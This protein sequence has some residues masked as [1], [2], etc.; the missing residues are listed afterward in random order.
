M[1]SLSLS[2]VHIWKYGPVF[3]YV[4]ESSN[5]NV[6]WE[7]YNLLHFSDCISAGLVIY[8]P[9]ILEDHHLAYLVYQSASIWG[10]KLLDYSPEKY[11]SIKL[12]ETY[13]KRPYTVRTKYVSTWKLFLLSFWRKL[14]WMS[15][16]LVKGVTLISLIPYR[17]LERRRQ[18][19]SLVLT[20]R[21][22]W[23]CFGWV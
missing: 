14:S 4:L 2:N 21:Q 22:S 5:N 10:Q 18:Y 12:Q 11:K 15:H 19:L 3:Q 6:I 13:F 1:T 8:F 23:L 9:Y 7:I 20:F 16:F 17:L